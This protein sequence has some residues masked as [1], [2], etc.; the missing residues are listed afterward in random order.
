M[1]RRTDLRRILLLGSGPIVIGQ[2]CEFDYS[3]TQTCKDPRRGLPGDPGQLQPG[4]DHDRSGDGGS[5]LYRALTPDL[6]TQVIERERPDALLPTMGGQTALNLAVN[7]AENGTLE[8]FGVE[9]IGADLQAIQKAE[10]RLLFKQAMERI[11]VRVCPSGIAS[12]LEEAE[13]VGAAIG[14]FP[15]IIRPAFTLGGSGGGIA[16]NPEYAAICKSG[17][18]EPGFADPDRAIPSGLEGVRAGSDARSGRQ[19]RDRLRHRELDPMESIPATQSPW[20]RPD[21]DGS[22]IPEA[23]RPVDRDHP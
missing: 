11:G 15:R 22:G 2:A 9:L 13:A 7:L 19:R 3:G 16:Y 5:D 17:L 18:G 14:S 4:V 6:V 21:P 10:D 12:T 1:P 20:P 23:A 8:R